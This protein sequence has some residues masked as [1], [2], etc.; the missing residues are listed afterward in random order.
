[1]KLRSLSTTVLRATLFTLAKLDALPEQREA[2]QNELAI[3]DWADAVESRLHA[4]TR[5][6][7]GGLS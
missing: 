6:G 1:M 5:W 7:R 3:R 2:I 4:T